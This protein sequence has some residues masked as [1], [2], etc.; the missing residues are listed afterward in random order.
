[1][2]TED[3]K[4]TK[5]DDDEIEIDLSKVKSWFKREKKEKSSSHHQKDESDEE[6]AEQKKEKEDADSEEVSIDYRSAMNFF[7]KYATVFLI[8]IP[9]ILTIYLRLQPM[10]LPMTDEWAQNTVHNYYKNQIA[11]QVEQQYPNLPSANKDALI[12]TE[13]EKFLQQNKDLLKQQIEG[14]SQAFKDR[15]MYESGDSKYVYLG[16]IDSYFWMREARKLLNNGTVCDEIDYN[17]QLCYQDTYTRAPEKMPVKL[18]TEKASPYSYSI[19]YIYKFLKL[20]NPD[21]T[22]MQ[23][24]FYTPLVYGIIIAILSFLIGMMIAGRL[25]GLITSIIIS[26]NPTF[27][28]RTL[29]SDN[30]PL[31]VFFPV[32]I[33]LFFILTIQSNDLKKRY[34]YGLV[35]GLSISL[36]AYSWQ[37]WWFMFDFLMGTLVIYAGFQIVRK[38]IKHQDIKTIAR[39]KD[40]KDTAIVLGLILTVSAILI[41][42]IVNFRTFLYAF[43]KPFWFM[44]TKVAAMANYW[45]N[46]L[47]TVAEFNPGSIPSIISQMGG[48]LMFFIGLMGILFV[49]TGK[50]RISKEQKYMLGFGALIYLILVSD[51]GTS[52]GPKTY[53]MLTALPVVIGMILLLKSEQEVDVRIAILLV[54]W[55]VATTYAALIGVRFALLMVSAFGVAFGIT[56]AKIYKIVSGWISSELKINETITKAIILI[57]LLLVLISPVKAGYY[58]ASHFMPSV[59]DAWYD[60]LTKIRDKSKGDAI[61]NSWWDFGHWFKYLADRRVTLDGSSQGGPPLHWLGKLMITDDERQSVGILR[62]LD[63][64]S[65]NAFDELDAVLNDTPKSIDI[66]D[67]I[68]TMDKKDAGNTLVNEGLTKE[69]AGGVLKYTHCDPP[70]DFF[71]TSEDMVGKSGVWA[72]FGSWDFTRAEMYNKVKGTTPEKGKAILEDP[73]YNFTPEQVDQYYYEIQTQDD[74][75]WI[76]PWPGYLSSV[77]PCE[78]PEPDGLMVCNQ[79]LANGQQI[80]FII[81]LTDMDVV[82]PSSEGHRPTSIVYVTENGTE[83]KF[84][85]EGNILEFSIVLIPSGQGYS[86]LITHPYLANS[87]FTRLFYLEGHGLEHFDR[88]NDQ[89]GINGGR[90]IT[91]K[92]DW[93]GN[94]PNIFYKKVEANATTG[95]EI[96]SG[97]TGTG[98]KEANGTGEDVAE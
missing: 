21:I 33:V 84:F 86:S 40:L 15:M 73:R 22:I 25:A 85:E 58:A 16:D 8:L 5:K 93:E 34:G 32:L 20:F 47:V 45:P 59:N 64:G 70:E 54:I 48:K 88:F 51:Y 29:G 75:Q 55:F 68:V 80:P 69:E 52:L 65:N 1:M 60:S 3:A 26:V 63:C 30:D 83:E 9:V 81:N 78:N 38:L 66:L 82:I 10:H 23:A 24:S 18:G 14:T 28:S 91:W 4:E 57:V 2:T 76:T 62:M 98:T 79:M 17:K 89:T 67:E 44:G 43:N 12:E 49:M 19:L 37:G 94:D 96:P 35:T 56:M 36:Y 92:V 74:S 61:I 6:P 53:M 46:V 13:F 50:D 27:L 42:I 77:K 41:T 90:I 11:T 7:K 71:I 31:S 39:S 95:E 72:H 87:I 97:E